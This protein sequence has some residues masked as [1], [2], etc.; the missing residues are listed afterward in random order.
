MKIG[1]VTYAPEKVP[2]FDV[3][4]Y[5]CK[6]ADGQAYPA[7]KGMQNDATCFVDAKAIREDPSIVA[8]S[9]DGPAMRKNRRFNMPFDYVCPTHP[10]Y[11]AKI[12]DYVDSLTA[13]PSKASR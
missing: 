12:L 5:Y 9:K 1:L 8:V 13:N 7:A 2:G 6:T 4:V 3:Q 10:G 11:R